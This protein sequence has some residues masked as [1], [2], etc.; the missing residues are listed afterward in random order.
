ML[1]KG[2]NAETS[3]AGRNIRFTL[4]RKLIEKF[5]R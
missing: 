3:Q 2:E 4:Q 5:Q 1:S